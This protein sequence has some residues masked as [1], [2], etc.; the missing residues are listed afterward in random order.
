VIENYS[1][2]CCPSL[3]SDYASLRQINPE[4]VMVS[5]P[6][7]AAD[8]EWERMQGLRVD[9]RTGLGLPSRSGNPDGPPAMN[10]I[11]YGDPI[12]GLNAA[13]ALLVAIIFTSAAL[14]EDSTSISRRSN[15]CCDGGAVADRT[16]GQCYG[17]AR[18]VAGIRLCVRTAAFPVAATTPG[19]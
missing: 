14:A 19:Y 6:A 10:H 18:W 12:G 15:A 2:G 1:N 4:L 8:G 9:P 5:M 11:A 13:A 17:R 7:F 3:G 16:I